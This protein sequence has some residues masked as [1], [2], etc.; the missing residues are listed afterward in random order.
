VFRGSAS[1]GQQIAHRTIVP[2]AT[3]RGADASIIQRLRYSAVG[4]STGSLYLPHDRQYLFALWRAIQSRGPICQRWR[5]FPCFYFDVGKRPSWRHL[6]IRDDV[7]AA[8]AP[9]NVC[10]GGRR[11]YLSPPR[12]Q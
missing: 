3:T 1:P 4:S 7:N 2:I 11:P 5:S 8:F 12:A 9:G 6:L 10:V